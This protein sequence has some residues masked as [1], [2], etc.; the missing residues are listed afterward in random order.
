MRSALKLIALARLVVEFRVDLRQA[1]AH[2]KP[3]K[4]VVQATLE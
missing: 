4:R 3:L 2:I 1:S